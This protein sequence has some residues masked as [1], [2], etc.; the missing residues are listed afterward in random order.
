MI[1]RSSRHTLDMF[2]CQ[3]SGSDGHMS[4]CGSFR[5][6]LTRRWRTKPKRLVAWLMTNPSTA[7]AKTDDPTLLRIIAW[8]K[9][10]G[11]DG[12]TV[13]NLWPYRTSK[14]AELWAWLRSCDEEPAAAWRRDSALL[15]N[16]EVI[17][18]AA[19]GAHLHM[20]AFGA[21]ARHRFPDRVR[22]GLFAF[23]YGLRLAGIDAGMCCLGT[24]RD[25][26]PIHPMARGRH[27]V[28]DTARPVPWWP[29]AGGQAAP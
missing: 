11:Y 25:G 17:C 5:W 22:R 18:R 16:Q 28:P 7:D 14:P 12:L 2:K 15:E 13:V 27:R 9:R 6:K 4:A 1:K 24:T 29:S 26:A 10:W 20:V 3:P 19:A 8:S 21:E 23:E